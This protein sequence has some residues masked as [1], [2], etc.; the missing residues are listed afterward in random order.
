MVYNFSW[1]LIVYFHCCYFA[2]SLQKYKKRLRQTRQAGK[3]LRLLQ[4]KRLPCMEARE[5]LA[6]VFSFLHPEFRLRK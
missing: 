2:Y 6:I 4:R 3:I 5:P 1:S